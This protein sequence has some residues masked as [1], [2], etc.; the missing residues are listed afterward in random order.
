MTAYLIEHA[1]ALTFAV[2]LILGATVG[3]VLV[4]RLIR[5]AADY[6]EPVTAARL[7]DYRRALTQTPESGRGA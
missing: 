6:E 7:A 1:P 5:V 4:G 2:G 3:A